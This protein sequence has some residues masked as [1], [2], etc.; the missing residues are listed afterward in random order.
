MDYTKPALS[1]SDQILVL[2]QRGLII[3]NIESAEKLLN[4][5]SYFRFA[6]YLRV[7]ELPDRSFRSGST[8]EQV[9]AL[10]SFDEELRK[11]IFGAVQKIEISLRS[12]V[13]HQFSLAH[14]PFWFLEASLAT[15][16]P[17]FAENLA[18]LQREIEHTKEDFIKEHSVK[19][20]NTDFPPAWKMLELV[21]F[22]CLTKLYFN[23]ADTS[24]RKHIARSFGVAKTDA[25]ESWMKAVNALRNL[26]AHHAR[27][28]NRNLPMRTQLPPIMRNA[29]VNVTG[30]APT[31]CYAILC[32]LVYWLNAID[33]QNSFV[34]ELKSLFAKYPT[35]KPSAMGFTNGWEHEDLWK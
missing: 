29:W 9:S 33:P 25:L 27:V 20:G 5:V 17:K 26:C 6:A 10:Y 13:I 1:I 11:L 30:I 4:N 19:Y 28:W 2:Q 8:F 7:F 34:V 32:C 24:V 21:S 16:K 12:R 15:D 3:N 18:T 35:V 22:G 23:F 31:S 14:G